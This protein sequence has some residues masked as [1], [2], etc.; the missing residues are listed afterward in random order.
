MGA[1]VAERLSRRARD[2]KAVLRRSA[3]ALT[4]LLLASGGLS[5][6]AVS[7]AASRPTAGACTSTAGVTVVVDFGSAG[8]GVKTGCAGVAVKTGFEALVNA[9]FAITNVRSQPGFLCQIDAKPTSD[10]RSV[11]NAS[12]YWSYWIADRGGA[13][14]YSS[15]G[16]SRR[17]LAGGVEGWS[18]GASAPPRS[19]PPGP[20]V[21]TTTTQPTPPTA[22]PGPTTT[23][24]SDVVTTLAPSGASDTTTSVGSVR[25]VTTSTG[26]PSAAG[27]SADPAAG[28]ETAAASPSDDDD[29]SPVGLL[30]AGALLTGLGMLG[31]RT[32]RR[33]AR[34][35]EASA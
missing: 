33:R 35:A 7:P 34:D 19:P 5:L 11:P 3:V 13:W 21:A 10:C 12:S 4:G 32:A 23:T 9:G 22:G 31:V 28:V 18:F 25:N 20:V 27:D 26:P 6:L 1:A 16:A 8:G 14:T 15:S 17:P 2:V 29:G 24:T 30:A